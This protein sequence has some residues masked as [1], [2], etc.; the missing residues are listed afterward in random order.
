METHFWNVVVISV[1]RCSEWARLLN[2]CSRLIFN[3]EV[4]F[5]KR[6]FSAQQ[7]LIVLSTQILKTAKFAI[8]ARFAQ[9][10][11]A[12][13][14]KAVK[15]LSPKGGILTV[16]IPGCPSWLCCHGFKQV[17]LIGMTLALTLLWGT[18]CL[19]AQCSAWASP[20]PV[21]NPPCPYWSHLFSCPP[22]SI[23][24][25]SP[26]SEGRSS[27]SLLLECSQQQLCPLPGAVQCQGLAEQMA[28]T[29][30]ALT[31]S[32]SLPWGEYIVSHASVASSWTSLQKLKPSA[33]NFSHSSV[34][35]S[36]LGRT[37]KKTEASWPNAVFSHHYINYTDSTEVNRENPQ[38]I[39]YIDFW[40]KCKSN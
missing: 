28:V 23:A 31:S 27:P 25:G 12:C 16:S 40:D 10:G 11:S 20:G 3:K 4:F 14:K 34:E 26:R 2:T 7:N 9:P 29:A 18:S 8:A 32:P 6:T 30:W 13:R 21:S 19:W 37:S 36:Q 24:A 5:S 17:W 39:V 15:N 33:A 35:L 1:L 22:A 38:W